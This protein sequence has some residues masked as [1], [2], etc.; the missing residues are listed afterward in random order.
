MADKQENQTIKAS[1]N[2]F[3]VTMIVVSLVIGIGIFRTPAMVA[4]ATRTPV[5]FSPPGWLE[6]S[7]LCWGP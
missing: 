1:L 4:A 2:T 5:L 3:D 6:A 7:S